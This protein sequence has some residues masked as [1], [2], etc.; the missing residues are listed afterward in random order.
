MGRWRIGLG[1]EKT[2]R[3]EPAGFDC[4]WVVKLYGLASRRARTVLSSPGKSPSISQSRLTLC[5]LANVTT[6][7][8]LQFKAFA[9]SASERP[10][11]R[12]IIL[13]RMRVD[14]FHG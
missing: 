14:R 12:A 7:S 3:R 11:S 9:I 4:V 13:I 6:A 10:R 2:R 5:F 8:V 1:N